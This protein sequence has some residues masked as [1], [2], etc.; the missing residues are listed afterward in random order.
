MSNR[1]KNKQSQRQRRHK[2]VRAKIFGTA[3]VP[4]LSVHRSLGHIRAQLINDDNGQTLVSCS[5]FESGNRKTPPAPGL[6]R[7]GKKS[8]E[9]IVKINKVAE[10]YKVGELLAQ[11][12][13]KLDIKKVVFDRSSYKY[14][15][16]IKSLAE[17]ARAGG[18]Q[19]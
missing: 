14:H 17:G 15:G 1:Q 4:R 3:Q 5:D 7:A 2:R 6:R 8:K 11:K 10:A 18:L 19:F 12:A 16:R 13:R 9:Q